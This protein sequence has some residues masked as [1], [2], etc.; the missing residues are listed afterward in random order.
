MT[1]KA[2]YSG[3]A[4][5]HANTL[6]QLGDI[7]QY[8]I[9]NHPLAPLENEVF[10]V[11][12][13]GMAQW[14]KQR[15]ARNGEDALG[16][17][18]ALDV[19]L[20]STYIWQL[21][22]H[23]LDG[24]IPTEQPLSKAP[25]TWRI[26]RLLPQLKND[27]RFHDLT[28]YIMD[29]DTD[30]KRHQLAEQLAD[31]YDQYQV[32]RSD[33]LEAWAENRLVLPK[34]DADKSVHPMP[35]REYW[36]AWLWQLIV[37]DVGEAEI[38]NASRSSVHAAF[39]KKMDTGSV[40]AELPSRVI[41]FGLS[42]LPKQSVQALLR[43]SKYSQVVLFVL[44]PC[45][46]YWGHI[47]EHKELLKATFKRQK[48]KQTSN[49]IP[50]ENLHLDVN[51]LL[52]AWGKQGR[53]YIRM[54]DE[55]DNSEIYRRWGWLGDNGC[56]FVDYT[57]NGKE[58]L[59]Q[60][61]QQSIL[62]LSSIPVKPE[63]LKL[64]DQSVVFHI[65]HSRQREVEILH[66]QLLKRFNDAKITGIPLRPR[67]IIVMVPDINAYAP[68]IH[69]VFGQINE[70]TQR[71]IPYG[72][73]D[74]QQ[75]GQNPLLN[76]VETLLNLADSRFSV[77][78]CLT[79]LEVPA[80]RS[81][82]GIEASDLSQLHQW[83]EE[84]GIRWGLNA[85]QR[86]SLVTGMPETIQTNT[87]EFGLN[88]MLLGYAVGKGKAFNGIEPY[89]EI[90]GLD[91]VSLGGLYELIE[92]MERYLILFA[93]EQNYLQ[94]NELL[95]SLLDD[96]FISTSD[97]EYKTLSL[98]VSSLAQWVT[99]CANA[100]LED[101]TLPITV[102]REAWLTGVDEPNLQQ[103]FLSGKV[104]FCTLTPMRSIPFKLVC[105]LG[106]NDGDFPRVQ[107]KQKF[108]LMADRKYYRP[109]DR[110]RRQDDQYLFLE[111][112]LSASDA[113]YI[114]WIGRNI[115]DNSIKTPSLLVS[116]LR[117]FISQG[118][119]LE[120][121][122]TNCLDNLTLHH[123][124]QP[125]SADYIRQ[126]RDKRLFT[127]SNEWFK[128]DDTSLI[129]PTNSSFELPQSVTLDQLARFLGAPVKAFC[130]QSL[131]LY[132]EEDDEVS[133]DI[134]SFGLNPLEKYQ[135]KENIL[136]Q[137]LEQSSVPMETLFESTRI[138][139]ASEGKLPL[140]CFEKINFDELT[141]D[142]AAAWNN[143]RFIR[144]SCSVAIADRAFSNEVDVSKTVVPPM[145]IHVTGEF[146]QLYQR[147]DNQLIQL[148]VFPRAL[149]KKDKI[150]FHNLMFSWVH[151][152]AVNTLEGVTTIICGADTVIYMPS[153]TKEQAMIELSKLVSYW[154]QGMQ[155][156]LPVGI[157]T[158]FSWLDAPRNN[159]DASDEAEKTYEGTDIGS[160]EFGKGEVHYDRYLKRFYPDFSDLKTDQRRQGFEY[161]VTALYQLIYDSITDV[162]ETI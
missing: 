78:A 68:H 44:N 140:G 92:T 62:E 157:K 63:L 20:P 162:Q 131:K 133:E 24:C 151:H 149:I 155:A 29:D 135:A 53:D 59:L 160:N 113:L 15:L 114:S 38:Q 13:S 87:W 11:N 82:F 111:A 60:Q 58:N 26:Y 35:E 22:R 54:L 139:Q 80:L 61:I 112:L 117:D 137:L 75:R 21:Y 32:Y 8:W 91:A 120:D 96:F 105:M 89:T 148:M 39:I 30:H 4:V 6:E 100:K 109:G 118:W 1:P 116:Q 108:D 156:P 143:Y 19:K 150:Q 14:L 46:H 84:S 88:R 57:S 102:V 52:A 101:E 93:Q 115:R 122:E 147:P 66:D 3:I 34:D 25:L 72:I 154:L 99:Y 97:R 81:K 121:K 5:I 55:F 130:N 158:A 153:L 159:K 10:L 49:N 141:E 2:L 85:Q 142:V 37:A 51:P 123:P 138:Q 36:Q 73:V 124:L 94:W 42:T 18:S 69:A 132:F 31:L 98:L 76:A 136:S 64:D 74:Q 145:M 28:G 127:Y 144:D 146:K 17:A 95:S 43:I 126:G 161:W 47:I 12:N 23:V 104:N 110:S 48:E 71:N 45:Q 106:M 125:F 77:S 50:L 65:G 79:L 119:V 41:V 27:N 70:D 129:E 86:K 90:G 128:Q 107:S 103:R 134:E 56:Y 7:V 16:I 40:S 152:L 33:W 67:E 83:I 9:K